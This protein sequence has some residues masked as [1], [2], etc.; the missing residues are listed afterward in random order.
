MHFVVHFAGMALFHFGDK[1][2]A[3][4]KRIT[5][6]VDFKLLQTQIR[7]AV[8]HVFQLVGGGQRLLLLIQNAR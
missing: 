1:R 3:L 6:L 8:G 7:D 4:E 5:L 2:I